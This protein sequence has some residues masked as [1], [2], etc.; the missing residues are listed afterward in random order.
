MDDLNWK[1]IG[2][3]CTFVCNESEKQ[4][5]VNTCTMN[6][7]FSL[8]SVLCEFMNRFLCLGLLFAT[9]AEIL[10][11][12]GEDDKLVSSRFQDEG[13]S[14]S[15]TPNISVVDM[16]RTRGYNRKDAA[17]Q[18]K[19]PHEHAGKDVFDDD[20]LKGNSLN[21]DG[22]SNRRKRNW[23]RIYKTIKPPGNQKDVKDI[24]VAA[25]TR[26]LIRPALTKKQKNPWFRTTVSN[27]STTPPTT[28]TPPTTLTPPATPT[29]R[30]TTTPPTATTD[31][32]SNGGKTKKLD[33]F[34][35]IALTTVNIL[36]SLFCIVLSVLM[37][38]Y[39]IRKSLK[40]SLVHS[41]Y[42]QNGFTD[43][44]VGMG[45]L[46]QCPIVYI[47]LWKG[48]QLSG[49]DIPVYMSYIVTAVAVKMSVFMNCVLGTVRCINIVRPFY[50][51]NKKAL[52]VV[53]ILYLITWMLMIGLDVWQYHDKRGTNNQVY[54]VKTFVMKPYAG[55]GPILAAMKKDQNGASFFAYYLGLL[56]QFILPTVLPTFIC[57]V[58]MIV[59]VLHLL[60]RRDGTVK[61]AENTSQLRGDSKASLTIFILTCIYVVT[62]AVSVVI[63]LEQEIREGYLT[64]SKSKYE[65]LMERKRYGT[66]WSD[67]TM[68]Y[69]SLST[70]P[71]IC[72][73]LTPLTLLL[74]GSSPISAWARGLFATTGGNR[75]VEVQIN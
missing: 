40:R 9:A 56:L 64:T 28:P 41:L 21:Q 4:L 62:S 53:T 6:K 8:I 16:K 65:I 61:D 47:M 73:T 50:Q 70:C 29:T 48:K 12:S 20:S 54:L 60:K 18:S 52:T 31:F 10:T 3:N 26:S 69:F 33:T 71:L 45:V 36:L 15:S 14:F 68:M 37:S 11:V 49:M 38:Y 5:G 72:S 42:L 27:V 7:S 17:F 55:F 19:I 44:F 46:S 2:Y 35:L 75:A 51:I 24:V 30:L 25:V 58:L 74:R 57:T 32:E 1:T 59:Q 23:H 13:W 43:L 66:T 34:G 63:L 67:L 39:R 22:S